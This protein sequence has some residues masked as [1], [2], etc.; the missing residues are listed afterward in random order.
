MK[1][2][3]PDSPDLSVDAFVLSDLTFLE[4]G[5]SE[6]KKKCQLMHLCCVLCRCCGC[7]GRVPEIPPRPS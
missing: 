1:S 4:N 6:Q 7:A 2:Q 3:R 5:A